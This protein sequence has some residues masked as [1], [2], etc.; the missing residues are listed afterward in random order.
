MHR[1]DAQGRDGRRLQSVLLVL[2]VIAACLAFTRPAS[3]ATAWS[4]SGTGTTTVVSD[5]TSGPAEF[6][7]SWE[8]ACCA[9]GSWTFST[10]ADGT[11]PVTLDWEYSGYH[12]FF[13]VTVSLTA[14][15]TSG[16]VT[17]TYP[18]VDDGP[19]NCCSPPSGGF[20]YADSTAL[21]VKAGD[22]F[23]FMLSGSNSD[24]DGRLLGTLSVAVTGPPVPAPAPAP[25]PDRVGYCSAQGNR[26][27]SSGASIPPGTFLNLEVNQPASDAHYTGAT[28]AIFVAAKGITCDPPPAGYVRDGFA[29]DKNVPAGVYAYYRP[30]G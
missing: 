13:A 17:T 21:T 26:Y 25:A 12:S 27:A 16:G 20:A 7:Y 3:A 30:A 29:V 19:V 23:G 10:V 6:S 22:T 11:G 24:S 14:F 28:L 9:T 8:E 2:V 18:L 15:V 5:G 4:A 1:N